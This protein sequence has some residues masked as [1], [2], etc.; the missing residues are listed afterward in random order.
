MTSSNSQQSSRVLLLASVLSVEL[1]ITVALLE[2]TLGVIAGNLFHLQSQ[3]WLDFVAKFASIVLTFS[4]T[5]KLPHPRSQPAMRSRGHRCGRSKLE[6]VS[7][8]T[9]TVRMFGGDSSGW[10]CVPHHGLRARTRRAAS[11]RA[12]RTDLRRVRV[13]G[14]WLLVSASR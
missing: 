5:D 10:N 8:H 14:Q 9:L 3:E 13:A 6:E 2:L 1:G 4:C 7:K 12:L 11:R